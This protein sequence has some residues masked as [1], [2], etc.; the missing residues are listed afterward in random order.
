MTGLRRCEFLT[1]VWHVLILLAPP[2]RHSETRYLSGRSSLLEKLVRS[3]HLVPGR[4]NLYGRAPPRHRMVDDQHN[5]R[6]NHGHQN[7]PQVDSGYARVTD[8]G[9]N[10]ASETSAPIIPRIMSRTKPSP[11]LFTILLPMNPEISPT[12][13]HAM[14]PM[15]FCASVEILE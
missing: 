15:N 8:R 10:F 5:D 14:I 6:A 2:V 1:F 3:G 11:D 13:S 9:E 12:I 7:A 4:R